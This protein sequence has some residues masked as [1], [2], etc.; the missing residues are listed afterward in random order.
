MLQSMKL[1][2]LAFKI[3]AFLFLA[4]L[5]GI[6]LFIGTLWLENRSSLTLP[7]PSGKFTVGRMLYDWVDPARSDTLADRPGQPRELAVW[8]WYPCEASAGAQ[9]APYLPDNWIQERD[10]DQGAG[11]LIEHRFGAIFTHSFSNLPLAP[12]GTQAA[13]PVLVMEPGMGP[14]A[15]DYTVLAENLASL[16]YIVVGIN[17]TDTSN[18]I[19]FPDGRVALRSTLGSIP[20]S[21]SAAAAQADGNRI[22][23][24]WTQ[25]IRF[26]L[27]RLDQLNAD[28]S[29]PFYRRLDLGRTGI[30]GHS[31][32]GATAF[33]IC[34]QD[35]RCKAGANLDG[36]PFSAE[37]KTAEHQPFLF[38]SEDFPQG[39]ESAP[40]CAPMLNMSRLVN[41]GPAYFLQVSGAKHFNFSDLPFRQVFLVRPLFRAAGYVGSI[42]PGRGLQITN[43]YLAAFFDRY[44]KGSDNGLLSGPSTQ[45]PEVQFIH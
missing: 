39:C 16:G 45:Y 29:S 3:I 32:G 26:V 22:L 10:I 27:D 19:V 36:D 43:T 5:V 14:M 28:N 8:V 2:K 4:M 41:P 24:V 33:A 35:A 20:D 17:P 40:N 31:F 30:F 23:G 18:L 7:A 12:A 38:L 44:L 21:D 1:L 15:A 11:R 9:A 37:M 6:G 13:F 34:Q 25:D 42:D